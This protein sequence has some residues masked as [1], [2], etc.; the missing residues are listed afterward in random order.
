MPITEE[1]AR[2]PPVLATSREPIS[3]TKRNKD[4]RSVGTQALNDALIIVGVSWLILFF[5]AYT[6]RSHNI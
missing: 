6:L 1:G 2:T 3:P 5:L 4:D